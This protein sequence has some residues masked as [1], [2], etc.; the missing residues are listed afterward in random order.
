MRR[1]ID[2]SDRSGVDLIGAEL[3]NKHCAPH[4]GIVAFDSSTGKITG[5]WGWGN[6][7]LQPPMAQNEDQ[8]KKK[9]VVVVSELLRTA[10]ELAYGSG[11]G[12][13]ANQATDE[14]VKSCLNNAPPKM[15]YIA[16]VF[17]CKDWVG[18]ARTDCGLH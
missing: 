7:G 12:V 5:A 8:W 11:N 6:T 4:H 18:W 3:S 2:L 1:K 13:P 17:D 15:P 10:S 16:G 14:Q 9:D